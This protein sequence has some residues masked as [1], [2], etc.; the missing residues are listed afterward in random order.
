MLDGHG[1]HATPEMIE[2]ALDNDIILFQL[3][4]HT[5][6]RL[7]PC[8]VGAFGPLKTWW[9]KSCQSYLGRNGI[10]LPARDVVGVY[11]GARKEAFKAETIKAAWRKAGIDVDDPSGLPKSNKGVFKPSDFKTSVSSSTTLDLPDGYIP[12]NTYL[13]DDDSENSEDDETSSDSES[14]YNDSDAG[15]IYP[16]ILFPIPNPYQTDSDDDDDYS[17]P[18]TGIPP[19]A[20]IEEDLPGI[21]PNE[22]PSADLV[23]RLA[24]LV[25]IYRRKYEEIKA[26]NRETEE[27][28]EDSEAQRKLGALHIRDLQLQ[29]NA[30]KKR[31]K[32]GNDRAVVV[33]SRIISTIELR[34]TSQKQK[35][36]KEIR[37]QEKDVRVQQRQDT[38][39][40]VR[41][42][43]AA[44]TANVSFEG[45]WSVLK[46]LDLRNL[47]WC[48][49]LS[50]EGTKPV[51]LARVRA[52]FDSHPDLQTDKRFASLFNRASKR[53]APDDDSE[54]VQLINPS[55]RLAQHRHGNLADATNTYQVHHNHVNRIDR[56]FQPPYNTLSYQYLIHLQPPLY[57]AGWPV[58]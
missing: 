7:Q 55:L 1:S 29:L 24:M 37:Q 58:S 53:P 6:H 52:Y 38:A 46:V 13:T 16:A 20:L 48:L 41:A 54:N 3:P 32:D 42:F 10:S 45:T 8:D 5:T 44:G 14:E 17:P 31:K 18:T 11:V 34:D 19:V 2:L 36:V 49:G 56:S 27:H 26:V 50:E 15:D 9:Y 39:A 43:R 35:E 57:A 22:P 21:D 28:L 30:K 23:A 47:A 33:G 40:H 12:D 4:P 51:L 25:D